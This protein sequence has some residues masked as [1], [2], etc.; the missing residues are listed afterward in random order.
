[1]PKPYR[2]MLEGGADQ[3]NVNATL[4]EKTGTTVHHRK[5]N[6]NS[7]KHLQCSVYIAVTFLRVVSESTHIVQSLQSSLKNHLPFCLT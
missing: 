2:H 3:V 4:A 6:P 1:M 7:I 5:T